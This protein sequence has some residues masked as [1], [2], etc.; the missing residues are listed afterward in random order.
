MQKIVGIEMR[1]GVKIVLDG[2][3]EAKRGVKKKSNRSFPI[4]LFF[5]LIN[6]KFDNYMH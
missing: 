1:E 2:V 5:I 3:N 4:N 6:F